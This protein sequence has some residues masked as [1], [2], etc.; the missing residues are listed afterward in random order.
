ME[1]G[2][3]LD[4]RLRHLERLVTAL[5]VV[6]GLQAALLSVIAIGDFLP[7]LLKTIVFVMLL[8]AFGVLF[9]KQIPHWFGNFSRYVFS[10]MKDSKKE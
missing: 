7:S 1:P 2:D 6:S 4:Q 8:I 9:R 10:Q 5:L 3:P